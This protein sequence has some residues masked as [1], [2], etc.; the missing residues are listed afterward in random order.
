MVFDFA[1]TSQS[2]WQECIPIFG[3]WRGWNIVPISYMPMC[4]ETHN[5]EFGSLL[6]I[7]Y[8]QHG[9]VGI[10]LDHRASGPYDLLSIFR[11]ISTRPGIKYTFY[12]RLN[13]DSVLDDLLRNYTQLPKDEKTQIESIMVASSGKLE[14]YNPHE[15]YWKMKVG[16][17][18][19]T[20]LG[21]IT[22]GPW[23]C[24][25]RA[26]NFLRSSGFF[27]SAPWIIEIYCWDSQNQQFG[28]LLCRM[29]ADAWKY[30]GLDPTGEWHLVTKETSKMTSGA[31]GRYQ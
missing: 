10:V 2:M 31:R 21:W 8:Q 7:F 14:H 30:P 23:R 12:D 3:R 29:P 6:D 9:E 15:R 28:Q 1:S 17:T 19:K 16:V 13:P 11:A 24:W 27:P 5:K 26:Y 22:D 25:Y 4:I 20:A 18:E